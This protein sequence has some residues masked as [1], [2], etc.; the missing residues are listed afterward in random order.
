MYLCC[1]VYMLLI[2]FFII[3]TV[4]AAIFCAA[5]DRFLYEDNRIY[6]IVLNAHTS[7]TYTVPKERYVTSKGTVRDLQI[8]LLIVALK[9]HCLGLETI[10]KLGI[11]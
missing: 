2:F 5:F 4:K 10:L 11:R 9:L 3:T 1:S 7:L 8:T 6:H